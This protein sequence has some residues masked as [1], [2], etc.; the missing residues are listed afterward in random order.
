MT[1]RRWMVLSG[2]VLAVSTAINVGTVVWCRSIEDACIPVHGLI[3]VPATVGSALMLFVGAIAW[4]L[5]RG[6]E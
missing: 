4:V 1:P 2:A 5:H 3:T 6:D